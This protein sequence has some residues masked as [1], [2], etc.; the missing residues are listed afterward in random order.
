MNVYLVKMGGA[1]WK[2]IA[3]SRERGHMPCFS[4]GKQ[5]NQIEAHHGNCG[6]SA[7]LKINPNYLFLKEIGSEER[8]QALSPWISIFTDTRQKGGW[9]SPG[10]SV[11]AFLG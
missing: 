6:L 7:I 5:Q 8:K 2:K 9:V 4:I 11:L 1:Y 3:I 10:S